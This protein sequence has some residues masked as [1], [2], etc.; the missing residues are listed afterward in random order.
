MPTTNYDP[1][2]DV[3]LSIRQSMATQPSPSYSVIT[4][5]MTPEG[6]QHSQ[7]V[8]SFLH[9]YGCF[10]VFLR[11][12]SG[13]CFCFLCF[14]YCV[15]CVFTAPCRCWGTP[16]IIH[17]LSYSV[18]FLCLQPVPQTCS[19]FWS[20]ASTETNKETRLSEHRTRTIT[21]KTQAERTN[22]KSPHCRRMQ[23]EYGT[24]RR[25]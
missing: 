5:S 8:L 1:L 19:D 15:F 20:N 12:G 23:N 11:R 13:S 7:E 17:F 4:D 25:K 10:S 21:G 18:F 9:G 16:S 2:D 6:P 24:K 14:F 22:I 3:P